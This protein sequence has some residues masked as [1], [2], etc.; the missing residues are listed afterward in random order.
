MWLN[1]KTDDTSGSLGFRVSYE[2]KITSGTARDVY[3]FRLCLHGDS[4]LKL[5]PWPRTK[6]I[7]L[8]LRSSYLAAILT[9]GLGGCCLSA[10]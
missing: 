2:G 4:L 6:A 3:D 5:V 10:V 8:G 9:P 7:W 1:F